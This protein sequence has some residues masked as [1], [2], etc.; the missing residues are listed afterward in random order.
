MKKS[1]P[2][3]CLFILC[4]GIFC[5]AGEVDVDVSILAKTGLSWN[6]T[7]LPLYRAHKPE[8]TIL[9]ITIPPG[10]ILPVHRHPVI[11]AGYMVRGELSV[12]TENGSKLLL[13]EGDAIIEVVDK[14]HY[15]KNEGSVPAIIVIFYAG[16]EGEPI[17]IY[18]K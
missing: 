15:G 13:K 14:W 12:Y 2:V 9:K 6:G 10:I 5:F 17:T 7:P 8:I 18:K 16:Y 11:N 4:S 3:I 1:F